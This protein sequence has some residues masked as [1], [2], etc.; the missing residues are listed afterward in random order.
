M[1][2]RIM[3][4]D[5][6]KRRNRGW[7]LVEIMIAMAVFSI[8]SLALAT[9]FVFSI[10][11]FAAVA[12]YAELDSQNRHAM[13]LLTR[14]I[15]QARQVVSYSADPPAI[16]ILD[17]SGQ[18]VRYSFDGSAGQMRRT[19]GGH[20]EILLRNCTLL[21]FS[22]YQRNPNTGFELYDISRNNTAKY[23]KAVELTWRTSKR[24]NP[25]SRINSENVQTARIVIRKQSED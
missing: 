17:G 6:L 20:D 14:E 3:F 10:R 13:D 19:V 12:N 22:L 15:R 9:L 7:T 4:I 2:S 11:S 1:G 24:L 8:A 16:A 23:V 21:Q 25:T 5:V 18:T